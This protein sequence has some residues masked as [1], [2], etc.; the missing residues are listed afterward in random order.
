M[1]TQADIASWLDVFSRLISLFFGI[2]GVVASGRG[3][4]LM[5][6]YFMATA[7]WIKP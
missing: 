6:A 4:F 3:D 2:S 1:M 7:A 5:A